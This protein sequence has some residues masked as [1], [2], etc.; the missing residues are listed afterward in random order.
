MFGPSFLSFATSILMVTLGSSYVNAALSVQEA[1]ALQKEMYQFL[2]QCGEELGYSQEKINIL[3]LSDL[4]ND[5]CFANC[6]YKKIDLIKDDGKFDDDKT[7]EIFKRFS[8]DKDVLESLTLITKECA[9][10]NDANVSDGCER[11]KLVAECFGKRE[12]EILPE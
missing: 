9:Q 11:A 10:A 4:P 8:N 2:A 7:I 5:A 1:A 12:A 3:S 6:F